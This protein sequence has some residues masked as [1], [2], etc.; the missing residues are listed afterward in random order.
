MGALA[1]YFIQ[2]DEKVKEVGADSPA[3]FSTPSNPFFNPKVIFN[4]KFKH[5]EN[6]QS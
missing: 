5:C 1:F 6:I 3:P 4:A 2:D